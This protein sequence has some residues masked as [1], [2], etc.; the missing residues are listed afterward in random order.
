MKMI[1]KSVF[2][3]RTYITF[4]QKM[5]LYNKKQTDNIYYTQRFHTV[6][7]KLALSSLPRE[8]NGAA[9]TPAVQSEALTYLNLPLG[10]TLE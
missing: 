10:V 3:H 6:Y 8:L 2:V 1:F 9:P 7:D 5:S 4:D